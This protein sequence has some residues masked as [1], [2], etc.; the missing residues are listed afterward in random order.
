MSTSNNTLLHQTLKA[1]HAAHSL[2]STDR[3]KIAMQAIK[4][5]IPG[6]MK[7]EELFET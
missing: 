3:Q 4:G 1:S 6:H 5:D 2:N 7:S